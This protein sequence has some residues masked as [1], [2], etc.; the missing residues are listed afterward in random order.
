MASFTLTP[1]E[2]GILRCRHT[3]AFTPEEV[4]TLASFLRRLLGQA[5]D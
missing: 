4:Q 2:K 1:V 3:G 5:A